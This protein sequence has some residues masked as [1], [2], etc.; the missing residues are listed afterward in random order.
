MQGR[1]SAAG[2]AG[3]GARELLRV[4]FALLVALVVG[5]LAWSLRPDSLSA[6]IDVVGYPS[7]A[8]F[9]YHPIVWGW[10]ILIWLA[11][12][13][14]IAAY[15]AARRFGPLRSLPGSA[16]P[17]ADSPAGLTVDRDASPTSALAAALVVPALLVC[18]AV[19]SLTVRPLGSVTLTGMVAGVVYPAILLATA[20]VLG[21]RSPGYD[22]P[23]EAVAIVAAWSGVVLGPA[24]MFVVSQR[25]LVVTPSGRDTSWS[26]LP[27]WLAALGVALGLVLVARGAGRGTSALVLERRVR[28]LLLGAVAAFVVHAALPWPYDRVEGYDDSQ[29]VVGALLLTRGEVP[30]RDFMFIHGLFEDGLRSWMGFHVF[31]PTMWGATAFRYIVL[32]P[33]AFTLLYLF[34]VWATPRSSVLPVGVVLVSATGLPLADRWIGIAL[35]FLLLGEVVRRRSRWWTV[36]LAVYLFVD[37]VLVP[38]V[39]FQV[40]ATIV[41]LV[42]SDLTSRPTG[43]RRWRAVPTVVTFAVTGAI[44]TV[45]FFA[46]LAALGALTPFVDYA[47]YFGPGHFDSGTLPLGLT[48]RPFD[49]WVMIVIAVGV[50]AAWI[51]LLSRWLRRRDLTHLHWCLLACAIT[52]AAYAEKALGR[53]DSGHTIQT[54]TATLPLLVVGLALLTTGVDR[55]IR[56]SAAV[57]ASWTQPVT[58]LCV[59]SLLLVFPGAGRAALHTPSLTQVNVDGQR[60]ARVGYVE[61]DAVSVSMLARIRQVL[62]TYAG[63]DGT[64][65]DFTNSLGY[66]YFLLG[67]EP[68][69]PF[70]HVSIAVT[71][72][73]QQAVIDELKKSRPPVVIFDNTTFGL[74]S[75]DGPRAEVRHYEIAQYLLDHWTPVLAA[76]GVLYLARND[77][78]GDEAPPPGLGIPES[79]RELFFYPPDCDWGY[80]ANYVDSPPTGEE[81][82]LPVRHEDGFRTQMTG[83]AYDV[84]TDTPV[85]EVLVVS[86]SRIVGRVATG[87]SRPDL[88][89]ALGLPGSATAG[90]TGALSFTGDHSEGVVLYAVVGNGRAYVISPPAGYLPPPSL[91]DEGRSI[92]VGK[93]GRYVGWADNLNG[94]PA[95]VATIDL[96]PGTDLRDYRLATFEADGDLGNSQMTL[97][98]RLDAAGGSGGDNRRVLFTSLPSAGDDLSVRVGACLQWHGFEGRRLYLTQAGGRQVDRVVLSGVKD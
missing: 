43:A 15:L 3:H 52:A 59:L 24:V 61:P 83:W 4:V 40:M 7:F 91:D 38:E 63:Q 96:P 60:V 21:R 51:G 42:L 94:G 77:L 12:T 11:P 25:T 90:F 1:P 58:C 54:L 33:L 89:T 53:F 95:D 18:F 65:F 71:P 32:G 55:R 39:S 9:N 19:S 80:S 85:D 6:P 13:A 87:G 44:L 28:T 50:L 56:M 64:V 75:W 70:V 72:L 79:G 78:V 22:G 23:G 29:S 82:D 36:L 31:E 5:A 49:W 46:L 74:A 69:T 86:G 30:W 57:R 62:D 98:D 27:W 41:V 16:E 97:S 88:P 17:V 47:R 10:R 93:P 37:A 26:W 81:V 73:A 66:F 2:P 35:G 45:L 92:R 34:A 48:S 84:K 8:N 67:R 20:A 76:D 68:A 14:G